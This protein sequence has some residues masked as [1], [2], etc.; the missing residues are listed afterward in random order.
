MCVGWFGRHSP[1]FPRVKGCIPALQTALR[2]RSASTSFRSTMQL[3]ATSR[4]SCCAR[5]A[6]LL[7]S[8]LGLCLRSPIAPAAAA[9]QG[10]PR[11]GC[12][13]S[14]PRA[15]ASV[16]RARR[17]DGGGGA[18]CKP[19]APRCRGCPRARHPR[20]DLRRAAQ[21]LGRAQAPRK[22]V[23]GGCLVLA[24]AAASVLLCAPAPATSC[25]AAERSGAGRV[26][27]SVQRRL[28]RGSCRARGRI[29]V[30]GRSCGRLRCC[31]GAPPVGT[32]GGPGGGAS[33]S[34]RG[35]SAA[36]IP[37]FPPGRPSS[38]SAAF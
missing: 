14:R 35:R 13:G 25:H 28:R 7:P 17:V 8:R 18:P 29:Q 11:P 19:P 23:G 30:D 2:S 21:R 26:Q 20:G 36:P 27:R 15:A 38:S 4:S 24:V 12:S 32:P 33:V 6:L 31:G 22:R 3:S 9:G 5:C 1:C 37:A 16:R 10:H 34:W